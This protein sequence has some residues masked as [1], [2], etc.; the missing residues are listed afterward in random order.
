MHAGH[1]VFLHGT[2]GD[3]SVWN[4]VRALA[5]REVECTVLDL[6]DHGSSAD[7]PLGD[8]LALEATLAGELLRLG[9]RLTLVGHS[10]GGYLAARLA[11]RLPSQVER[12]VVIS[13]FAALPSAMADAFSELALAFL[14]GEATVATIEAVATERWYGEGCTP[15]Q[16]SVVAGIIRKMSAE[17]VRRVL[18]RLARMSE[19]ALRAVPFVQPALVVHGQGDRAVPFALGEEVARSLPN[20]TL[21]VVDTD[22]HLLP[23]THAE[24]VARLVFP[25]RP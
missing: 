2:P 1:F 9:P 25:S 13:G 19:P 22:F 3:A 7:E 15:E 4:G 14:R 16:R 11:N 12:A 10:Y 18:L 5:P 24:L 8:P 21:E 23:L 17:R 6:P 20:G